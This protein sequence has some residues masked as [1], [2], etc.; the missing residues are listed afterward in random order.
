LAGNG[1]EYTSTLWRREESVPNSDVVIPDMPF[2]FACRRWWAR[3]ERIFAGEHWKDDVQFVIRGGSFGGTPD[4]A[5]MDKRIYSSF[6]NYGAYGGFRLAVSLDPGSTEPR[7]EASPL[8]NSHL[9][10]VRLV[11]SSDFACELELGR[12]S[13]ACGLIAVF[14]DPAIPG[15]DAPS[16]WDQLLRLR[17]G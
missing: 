6:C 4:D 5:A 16:S 3:D 11:S 13:A 15:P 7:P 8:L 2:A 1:W 9:Q 17:H 10:E 14:G 12:F